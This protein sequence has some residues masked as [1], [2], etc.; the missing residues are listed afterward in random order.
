[1]W[2]SA[3]A[4]TT[5][6][7]KSWG[8]QLLSFGRFSLFS[9]LPSHCKELDIIFASRPIRV[10]ARFAP[11]FY[12]GSEMDPTRKPPC[13]KP[14]PTLYAPAFHAALLFGLALVP[15]R[16]SPDPPVRPPRAH[17]LLSTHTIA[18]NDACLERFVIGPLSVGPQINARNAPLSLDE[19]SKWR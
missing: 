7:R 11:W 16:T 18:I 12:L 13:E 4:A 3:A 10:T 15:Q 9:S 6:N 2:L 19:Q 14:L 17:S 5:Y 8:H 1:M